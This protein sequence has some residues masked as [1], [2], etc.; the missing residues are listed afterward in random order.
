MDQSLFKSIF[1][2][3]GLF[4]AVAVLGIFVYTFAIG[5][6]ASKSGSNKLNTM[7]ADL[8]EQD[9]LLYENMDVSGSAVINALKKFESDGKD[10]KIGVLVKT[11]GN[12]NGTWYYGTLT[13]DE[14]APITEHQNSKDSVY[15]NVYT[16]GNTEYV[17]PGGTFKG[18]I[19]RDKNNVIRAV[20]FDQK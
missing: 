19:K 2:G 17:N 10:G 7:T 16:T 18:S 4:F 6:D 15:G 20:V 13:G 1:M 12:P 11:K 14:L 3:V 9:Y 8:N 5:Q